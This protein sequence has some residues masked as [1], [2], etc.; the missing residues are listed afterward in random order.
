MFGRIGAIAFA[1]VLASSCA[2]SSAGE[3]SE[4][5][6][7]TS[8]LSPELA[9]LVA[10]PQT[11]SVN[12]EATKDAEFFKDAP[13]RFKPFVAVC[14][15][16]DEWD[17]PAPAFQIHGNTYHIGTCGISAILIT[18][19]QG[20][21][22]I[23]GGTEAGADVIAANIAS[24]GFDIGDVEY[25][26]HSHEHF[27]HA[28]GIAQLQRLSGARLIASPRAKPVLETGVVADDD[29]Q[30]GMHDPFPAATVF[31]TIEDGEAV[32]LGAI[33]ATAIFTPG[34]SPGAI[35]WQ[36]RSCEGE[37][38][39]W[40]VYADS[41]SPVSS[42]AYRFSDHPEYLAAYET[43]LERLGRAQCE[44]LLTPHPSHSRM[45]RRMRTDAMIQPAACAYYAMDKVRDI[46]A[47]L[48]REAGGDQ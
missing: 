31:Q 14:N 46:E 27:D 44:I 34:H 9:A 18:G 7:D 1:A 3:T 40:M 12:P 42:D 8:G 16:W 38:C 15:P 4:S 21:I 48:E 17:K 39:Y 10:Q 47:R 2:A 22:L 41:L 6:Q 11:G 45:I 24:L 28:A 35:S 25:I 20:H 37:L 29:P 30:A 23:D 26:L 13:E 32:E 5:P 43:G 36:W 33:R 19:E